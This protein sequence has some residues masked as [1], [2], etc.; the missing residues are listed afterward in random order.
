MKLS[1]LFTILAQL[2][3]ACEISAPPVALEDFQE[4]QQRTR[5]TG[6][7]DNTDRYMFSFVVLI[8]SEAQAND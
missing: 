1:L 2:L 3:A 8:G 4:R 7:D 5:R 6:P